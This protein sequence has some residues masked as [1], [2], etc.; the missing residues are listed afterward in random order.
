MMKE[1]GRFRGP[2]FYKSGRKAF[3]AESDVEDAIFKSM[4]GRYAPSDPRTL[5]RNQDLL[6][7]FGLISF[8]PANIQTGQH[9]QVEFLERN[10]RYLNK[11]LEF[12]IY[13]FK[14]YG[15]QPTGSI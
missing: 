5:E 9:A 13:Q 8:T 12:A 6:T 4:F 2:R 1:F 3:Q 7:Q 10:K 14:E 11:Y 15:L